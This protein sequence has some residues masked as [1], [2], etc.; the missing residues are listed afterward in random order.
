MSQKFSI[1]AVEQTYRDIMKEV[2]PSLGNIVFGGKV[3]VFGG[4]FRQML[5]EK[6]KLK[7]GGI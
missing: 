7:C 6:K 5:P 2:H 1:E 4:D 3:I